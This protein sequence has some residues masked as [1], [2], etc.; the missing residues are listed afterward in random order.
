MDV[1]LRALDALAKGCSAAILS[2]RDGSRGAP[3]SP[4]PPPDPSRPGPRVGRDARDRRPLGDRGLRHPGTDG[5]AAAARSRRGQASEAT[6]VRGGS[7]RGRAVAVIV[8]G[9]G[10]MGRRES[11]E[12]PDGWPSEAA[13]REGVR[14]VAVSAVARAPTGTPRPPPRA[15]VRG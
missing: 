3:H 15:P 4:R 2:A 5:A 12:P 14:A 6:P 1:F 9:T 10:D 7:R 11:N 8:A 13:A